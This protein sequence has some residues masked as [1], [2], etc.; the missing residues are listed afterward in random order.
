MRGNPHGQHL[1]FRRLLW[2]NIASRIHQLS[3]DSRSESRKYHDVA[4]FEQN[5][6]TAVAAIYYRGYRVGDRPYDFLKQ[7]PAENC[8]GNRM[9]TQCVLSKETPFRQLR[10]LGSWMLHMVWSV[11]CSQAT[12]RRNCPKTLR[13][14]PEPVHF[15]LISSKVSHLRLTILLLLLYLLNSNLFAGTRSRGWS[16]TRSGLSPVGPSVAAFRAQCRASLARSNDSLDPLHF[17]SV[18]SQT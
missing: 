4:L 17:L 14:R 12:R 11:V 5:T 7:Q 8:L 10:G 2:K 15:I 18:D 3:C 16:T 9:A 6:D 13:F 1:M